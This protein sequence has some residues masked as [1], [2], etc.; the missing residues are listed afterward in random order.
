MNGRR[1]LV[2]PTCA[3]LGC[4]GRETVGNWQYDST[5]PLCVSRCD[6]DRIGVLV[7]V[8]FPYVGR[9]SYVDTEYYTVEVRDLVWGRRDP[10][11]QA[12]AICRQTTAEIIADLDAGIAEL[13]AHRDRLAAALAALG[14][15]DQAFPPAGWQPC[16]AP[17]AEDSGASGGQQGC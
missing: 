4:N 16:V 3:W 6:S 2:R 10:A 7:S 12:G 13:Q 5:A 9:A 15:D 1:D 17:G 8:P 14:D 11:Y